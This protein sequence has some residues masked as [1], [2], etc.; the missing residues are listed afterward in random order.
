LKHNVDV[1]LDCELRRR[2]AFFQLLEQSV[3]VPYSRRADK[4]LITNW[5]GLTT[6]HRQL[7]KLIGNGCMHLFID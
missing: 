6:L 2:D 7:F 5:V 1:Q 4:D 3:P